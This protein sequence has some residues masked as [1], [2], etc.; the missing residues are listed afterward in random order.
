MPPS[1]SETQKVS[2]YMPAL[3]C[4]S[5]TVIYL[6]ILTYVGYAVGDS[7]AGRGLHDPK[8]PDAEVPF[9]QGAFPDRSRHRDEL[10]NGMAH[11]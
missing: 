10:P 1:L 9:Y 6:P 11:Q 8:C 3:S 2:E 5:S 7:T 4:T